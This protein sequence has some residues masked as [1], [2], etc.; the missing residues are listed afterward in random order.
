MSF[1]ALI[2]RYFRVKSHGAIDI[3]PEESGDK[4]DTVN[5]NTTCAGETK[6]CDVDETHEASTITGGLKFLFMPRWM[7]ADYCLECLNSRNIIRIQ[8]KNLS[9]QSFVILDR[10]C[11]DL[12]NVFCSRWRR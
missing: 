10:T 7:S 2:F 11:Q 1:L 4:N 12:V 5:V 8:S 3:C 9:D 6:Q